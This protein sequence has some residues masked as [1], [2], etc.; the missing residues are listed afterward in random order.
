M[1]KTTLLFLF[2]VFAIA[3][4]N[5][6]VT[7]AINTVTNADSYFGTSNDFDVLFKRNNVWYGN[8]F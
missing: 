7:Q 4:V 1:K 6:Q 2:T 8:V 3:K 5:A